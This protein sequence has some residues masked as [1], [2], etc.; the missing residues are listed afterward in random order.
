[1]ALRVSAPGKTILMGEHAAVFGRPAL[2]A[3]VDRRAVAEVETRPG[4]DVVLDLPRIGVRTTVPWRSVLEATRHARKAWQSYAERP[5]PEAFAAVRGED[6]A[7]LVK[8]ALG[9][10]AEHLGDA[11]PPGLRLHLDSTV[12]VGAGLGSS[13]AVAVAVTEAYLAFRGVRLDAAELHR[14]TL[15]VERRQHGLPS[16]V[17][18]ATVIHGGLV[19]ATKDGDGLAVAPL[20]PRS[21][22]LARI[23]L[24][25]SGEP[26][27]TTGAVVAAV[28]ARREAD[29]G[30]VDAVLDRMERST[31][32]LCDELVT[33]GER[34]GRIV[35]LFRL[36]EA[37]LETLGVVPPAVRE[38]LREV[39]RHGAGVKISGAGALSGQAAG[40]LL[41]YHA[42]T[43][44]AALREALR[45]VLGDLE[46]L[47]VRLGA[48][49][50]RHEDD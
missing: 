38:L 9:E 21:P 14:L 19:W 39:E 26:A 47:D 28:R 3:A 2:V 46:A 13:A 41:V 42:E 16:G 12:P 50:V 22:A 4:N 30:G 37:D 31:R 43:M 24:V 35:E 1:M 7:H 48:E 45:D 6:P 11:M 10:A 29:P 5:S 23:R 40:L 25:H 27:E 36:F 8:I 17:D 44:E 20:E 32:A 15:E 33:P 34:P 49:G 18:N